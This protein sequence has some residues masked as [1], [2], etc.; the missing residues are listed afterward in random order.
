MFGKSWEPAEA[1]I[2]LVNIKHYSGSGMTATREWAADVRKANGTV[3]RAKI[4]EPRIATNFWAPVAGDVVKVEVDA[5]SGKV[6]FDMDDPK[7][8]AK[9]RLR[10]EKDAFAAA[11][12]QAP[13]TPTPRS[14][15]GVADLRDGG[16]DAQAVRARFREAMALEPPS[17]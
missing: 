15:G 8:N 1:T 16:E 6:R 17:A 5:K 7:V 2:V 12:H 14:Q 9:A 4:D 13:G 11:L 3:V 10:A